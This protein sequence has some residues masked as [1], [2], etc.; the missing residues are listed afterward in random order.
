MGPA[1][2]GPPAGRRPTTRRRAAL[3]Q[4]AG[5]LL[6]ALLGAAATAAERPL[7]VFAAASLQDGLDAAL[8]GWSARG[9]RR[10]VV[11]Y[12]ASSALARQ[13]EQGAP[14][15]LFVSADQ[16]WMDYLETRG[17]VLPG[18]RADLVGNTLVVVAPGD[19]AMRALP[20]DA[21]AW[22]AALGAGGRLAIAETTTVPAGR[23]GRQSLEALG[24]WPVVR[25]RLAQADNVR[26]A[27]AF[28]A[29]GEAPLGIVYATDARAEPRVR[30]VAALPARS[31][32]P[33]TYPAARVAAGD[34]AAAGLLDYLRGPE[35]R[36]RFAAAGFTVP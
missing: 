24:L 23:Y 22:R 25:D 34:R 20:P 31:H 36:A 35:A 19:A 4:V 30:V 3:R 32:A 11:S 18:S 8:A 9:G 15:D 17:R 5:L 21:A 26:A 1:A 12:A 16:A 28:V 13:I 7:T 29:R 14:A 27:L 6:G 10:V 2:P 33:I